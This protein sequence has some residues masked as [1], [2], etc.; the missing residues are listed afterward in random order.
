MLFRS[1]RLTIAISEAVAEVLTTEAERAVYRAYLRVVAK[2]GEDGVYR[3]SVTF[4]S[5]PAKRQELA[6][7]LTEAVAQVVAGFSAD[8]AAADFVGRPGLYYGLA[9]GD[10]LGGLSETEARVMAGATGAVSLTITKPE[11]T[12]R[13]FY[14]VICSPYATAE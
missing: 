1:D 9:H 2:Q 14:R 3:A 8:T 12:G 10:E 6:E 5:D 4:T 11:G 13:H 7:D